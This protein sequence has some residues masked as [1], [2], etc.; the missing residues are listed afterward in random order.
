MKLLSGL[1]I[2]WGAL[3]VAQARPLVV[4]ESARIANPNPATYP[5]FAD[6]VAIDGDDAIATL[7]RFIDPPAGGEMNTKLR[8]T[9]FIAPPAGGRRSAS[10]RCNTTFSR[11]APSI[12]DSRCAMALRRSR[13][14][15][16]R[17]SSEATAT[18][19]PRL[20]PGSIRQS[21]RQHRHRRESHPLWRQQRPVDGHPLR[22]EF[23]RGLG[24]DVGH[25]RRQSQR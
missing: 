19:C 11:S 7:E 2:A 14:T 22:E 15:R 6:D 8:F 4:Q 5:I 16:C 17:S 23:R 13:S 12:P 18:G 20:S 21:G 3:A 9:C 1:F 24:S 10:S 25:G